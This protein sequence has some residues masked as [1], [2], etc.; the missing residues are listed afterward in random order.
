MTRK[1]LII[2]DD[3]KLIHLLSEYLE[4]NSFKV[5]HA[6][7]GNHAVDEIKEK[8]PDLIILDIMLP[9]KD[10]LEVLKDIRKFHTLPVIMLTAKGDDTDRIIGLELGA[11]DYLPKPFN[12]RELLARIK[13]VLRRQDLL[14][15]DD[16]GDN[17]LIRCNDM[18][19]NRAAHTIEVNQKIVDLSTT[20]FNILEVL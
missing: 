16:S 19:L 1:I 7:E 12:P 18:V 10:G 14:I 11:D 15:S 5:S 9:G 3:I 17:L 8:T 6:L 2:D 20:E 4:E 13:A